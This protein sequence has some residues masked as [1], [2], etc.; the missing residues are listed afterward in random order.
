MKKRLIDANALDNQL[1]E[2]MIRFHTMGRDKVVEDYNFVRTVLETALTVDAVEVVHGRN[3]G[4]E[5]CD[6][7]YRP[8]CQCSICR[9]YWMMP[10]EENA[11]FCPV[12]GAKMD[13]GNEDV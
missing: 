11:N 13:G 12:C 10:Y 3:I 5:E 7:W 1:S 9:G 4:D 8:I 2:L 6:E